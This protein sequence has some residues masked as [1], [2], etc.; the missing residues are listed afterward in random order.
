MDQINAIDVIGVAQSSRSFGIYF[1]ER[2]LYYHSR[3]IKSATGSFYTPPEV[4]KFIIETVGNLLRQEFKCDRFN[5]SP[6]PV[7]DIATG[8][9]AFVLEVF[10]QALARPRQ[11][12]GQVE[13]IRNHLLLHIKGFETTPRCSSHDPIKCRENA[14]GASN[15]LSLHEGIC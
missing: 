1:H 3:K 2:L 4:V 9:G 14:P 7:L 10:Q 8:T 15:K 11:D 6:L 12:V 13:L 5:S